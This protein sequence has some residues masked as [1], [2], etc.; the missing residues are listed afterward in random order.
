MLSAVAVPDLLV[1]L[2][3]TYAYHPLYS[4]Y[5][6]NGDGHLLWDILVTK[7][8]ECSG[9]FFWKVMLHC[10]VGGSLVNKCKCFRGTS[11]VQCGLGSVVGTATGYGLDGGGDRIPVGARFSAPVQTGPGAHWASCI[12]GTMSFRGV[13]SGRGVTLTPHPLLVPWSWKSRAIPLLLLCAVQPVQSLSACTRVHFTFILLRA[14][15][16]RR[17]KKTDAVSFSEMLAQSQ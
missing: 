10:W 13:K 5:L 2:L 1:S 15:L 16:C 7:N 9:F 12:M 8:F 14:V 4:K 6:N 3:V 11:C 17:K